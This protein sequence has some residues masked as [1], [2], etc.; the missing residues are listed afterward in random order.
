MSEKTKTPDD[1]LR[2]ADCSSCRFW[3]QESV[4]DWLGVCTDAVE[5]ARRVVPF[6]INLDVSMV[7][8]HGG[9]DCPCFERNAKLS[10]QRK[11]TNPTP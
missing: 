1:E 5:R 6:A 7:F 3:K 8:A 2:Q 10:D 4:T 11:E 9:K